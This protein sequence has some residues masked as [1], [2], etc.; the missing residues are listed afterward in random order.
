MPS[1]SSVQ[2]FTS[3]TSPPS[4]LKG[5]PGSGILNVV[6]AETRF[7]ISDITDYHSYFASPRG[8]VFRARFRNDPEPLRFVFCP[9]QI[10]ASRLS[11]ADRKRLQM[12]V[13]RVKLLVPENHWGAL[14]AKPEYSLVLFGKEDMPSK[15]G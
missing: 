2:Q 7:G 4:T 13:D 14:D 9:L 8:F 10:D 6:D 3:P 15:M 1:G 5:E 11:E 12:Y